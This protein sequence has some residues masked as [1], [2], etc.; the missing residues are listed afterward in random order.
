MPLIL[1]LGL[2]LH[3]FP[4]T[5]FPGHLVLCCSLKGLVPLASPERCSFEPWNSFDSW[6]RNPRAGKEAK[7]GPAVLFMSCVVL[8][9]KVEGRWLPRV[10][11]THPHCLLPWIL[12]G[13]TSTLKC[14]FED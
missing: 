3:T 14:C 13:R 1:A 9:G 5:D 4:G 8:E 2:I 11:G 7:H 6:L 10:C 12:R